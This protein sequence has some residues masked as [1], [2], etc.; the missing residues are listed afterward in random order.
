MVKIN[1]YI[2]KKKH[3]EKFEIEH[4]TLLSIRLLILYNIVILVV[5]NFEVDSASH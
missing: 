3:F 5:L 2:K 4:N 1:D